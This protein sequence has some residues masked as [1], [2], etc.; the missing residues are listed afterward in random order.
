MSCLGMFFSQWLSVS[1][2][3]CVSFFRLLGWESWDCSSY[4]AGL[5]LFAQCF[6]LDL[7]LQLLGA[8]VCDRSIATYGWSYGFLFTHI[9]SCL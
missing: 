9:R 7:R 4:A 2:S 3:V 1:R 6:H 5:W 8:F